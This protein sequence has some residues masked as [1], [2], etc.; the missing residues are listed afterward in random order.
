[1]MMKPLPISKIQ[2]FLL[3]LESFRYDKSLDLSIGY[4]H[5]TLCPLSW[6]LCLIVLPFLGQIWISKY[7]MRLCISPNIFQEKINELCNSLEYGR[8]QKQ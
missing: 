3:R 7:P 8:E 5:I 2:Y 4:F 6:N 1:M